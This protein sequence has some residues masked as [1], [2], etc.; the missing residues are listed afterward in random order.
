M[1]GFQR[2]PGGVFIPPVRDRQREYARVPLHK[3]GMMPPRPTPTMP[4][5]VRSP[6]PTRA[7]EEEEQIVATGAVLERARESAQTGFEVA[8]DALSH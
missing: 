6:K 7:Q 1:G 8:R 2:K 5:K 4:D 3:N